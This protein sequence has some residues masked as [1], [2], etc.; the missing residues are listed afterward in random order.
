MIEIVRVDLI[1]RHQ[2]FDGVVALDLHGFEFVLA[3]RDMAPI[4]DL[5][6]AVRPLLLCACCITD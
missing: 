3:D 4:G 1:V 5:V 6:T 2:A